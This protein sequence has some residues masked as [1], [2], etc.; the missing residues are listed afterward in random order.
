[1]K[2]LKLFLLIVITGILISCSTSIKVVSN[3][4]GSLDFSKYKTYNY[5]RPN[6]DSVKKLTGEMPVIINQLNQ[7][8]IE[9]AINEEMYLR[10]YSMADN[11]D[12]W[13]SYYLKVENKTQYS[14]TTYNYGS[15]YYGGYGY[16]GYYGGYGYGGTYTDVSS[17]DYDVGTLIIDLVDAEANELIWYGAGS[18]ALDYNP[19]HTERVINDAV[20]QI[21][22][23]YNFM[24][25]QK[26]P[27]KTMEIQR[28][29]KKEINN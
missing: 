3:Y 17:Y 15:P 22:Y 18:K 19:R 16:Y 13:V 25:S 2:T 12:I 24:A 8:R 10:E 28:K 1:M 9:K 14:A 29:R 7:R 26:E 20:T 21:F 23:K 4:N 11:P 6:P 27:L 5:M